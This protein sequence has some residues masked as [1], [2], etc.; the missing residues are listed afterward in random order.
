MGTHHSLIGPHLTSPSH[1]LVYSTLSN[2][3]V[4]S[5][6]NM[7]GSR[8]LVGRHWSAHRTRGIGEAALDFRPPNIRRL[9]SR[10]RSRMADR[11]S[12]NQCGFPRKAATRD[13]FLATKRQ[14]ENLNRH[15]A[16]PRR[17]GCAAKGVSS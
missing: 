3:E 7:R 16:F 1:H 4:T 12:C 6:L 8:M 11:K 17:Q 13:K 10:H 2:Y 9:G 14:F 15:D 5:T